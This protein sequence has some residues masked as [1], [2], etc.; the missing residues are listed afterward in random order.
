V[1]LGVVIYGIVNAVNGKA[2]EIP[3]IGKFRILT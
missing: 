2:V 3:L 1:L